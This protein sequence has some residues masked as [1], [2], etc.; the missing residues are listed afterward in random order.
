MSEIPGKVEIIEEGEERK[1]RI[2]AKDK[3]TTTEKEYPV[4]ATSEILVDDGDY[5][6]AGAALTS[7]HL[8]LKTLLETQ[9]LKSVQKY[10]IS[11]LQKVYETQGAQI[12]DKHFE[13][14]VRKMSEKV[15]VETS[16]DTSLLPGEMIDKMRF[17]GENAKVLAEGGEPATASIM[18]LGITRTALYTESVLSAASFQ[19]TTS[20]LTD[21]ATSGKIDYL[22]GLKE[23]VIIGR[24]IPTG[25]RARLEPTGSEQ[26]K[27]T[28]IIAAE[29]ISIKQP[30][31]KEPI[32]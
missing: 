16:G 4:P 11:E 19:E 18:I 10:I 26:E 29:D 32:F 9:G 8:Y 1:I 13:V 7:G 25:E 2:V 23:N 17:S 27:Q 5:V 20:V 6:E 21:A 24:L 30:Q 14:I 31:V 12:N 28:T 15:R 3:K 22:R